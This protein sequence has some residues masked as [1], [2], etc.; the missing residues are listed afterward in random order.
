MS[1]KTTSGRAGPNKRRRAGSSAEFGA[2]SEA[3][4][5]SAQNLNN[6]PSPSALSTRALPVTSVPALSTLCA[7]VF[8]A[9]LAILSRSERTWELIRQWLKVLPD[10]LVP[11]IFAMLRTS[12]PT[13]LSEPFIVAVRTFLL[14][15][16]AL[17]S[18]PDSTFFVDLLLP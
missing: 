11:K 10:S 15:F 16:S 17:I 14:T 18:Q 8:V 6:T 5:P 13:I 9:N 4:L 3:D 12:C 2:P 1:R 7:R